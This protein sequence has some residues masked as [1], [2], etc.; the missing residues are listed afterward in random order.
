[1]GEDFSL[2]ADDTQSLDH[3]NFMAI[4]KNLSASDLSMLDH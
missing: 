3:P 1:M 2:N 4:N